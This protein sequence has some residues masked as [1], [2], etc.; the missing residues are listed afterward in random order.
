MPNNYFRFKQF[1]IFQDKCAFK[2]GTDG[3]LLGACADVTGVSKILDIGTGTGLLL[4]VMIIYQFY[5]QIIGQHY[6][7]IPDNIK[8]L[9]GT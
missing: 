5:E 6:D 1:T 8:K 3:V 2:V 7:E 9:V 4:T